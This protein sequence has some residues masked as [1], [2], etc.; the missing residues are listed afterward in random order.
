MTQRRPAA[1]LAVCA[2]HLVLGWALLSAGFV[3]P[4]SDTMRPH[5]LVSVVLLDGARQAAPAPAAPKPAAPD[6]LASAHVATGQPQAAA[7]PAHG[8]PIAKPPMAADSMPPPPG[9]RGA[10]EVSTPN[11]PPALAG[12]QA[13]AQRDAAPAEP[14][15]APPARAADPP[16]L[17]AAH[18]DRRL[19]PPAPHPAALRE[20]GIEGAVLLRVL[21][22][23]QGRPA[24]V[25][26]ANGSGWRLFDEAALQ[27]VRACRFVPAT[28]GGQAID[29]W[30]EFPVRFAL[31]G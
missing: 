1:F 24:D 3:R 13:P 6:A 21:V 20:R 17:V 10:E 19:C 7:L 26:V 27:Q 11:E 2:A 12:A 28:Q 30:V 8:A 14:L 18:A 15:T 23:A 31:A 22:D 4:L 29:S 16:R 5:G 25:Q 9:H